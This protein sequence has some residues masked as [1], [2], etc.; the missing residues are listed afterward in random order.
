M[1]QVTVERGVQEANNGEVEDE[2]ELQRM[3][4]A[5]QKKP[6]ERDPSELSLLVAVSVSVAADRISI[7]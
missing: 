7:G 6:K 1:R 3:V 4:A 2:T 5:L